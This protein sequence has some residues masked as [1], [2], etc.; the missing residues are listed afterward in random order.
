V[1]GRVTV[2]GEKP[3]RRPQRGLPGSLLRQP[4]QVW[5]SGP[6]PVSRSLAMIDA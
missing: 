5:D 1:Y 6:H 2:V 3:E 4:R